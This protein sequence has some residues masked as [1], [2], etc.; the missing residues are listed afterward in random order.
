MNDLSCWE[1]KF[2]SCCYS[3][4]LLTKLLLLNET[5]T[6]KINILEIKK[7]I[8]YAK[9][10]HVDQKRQ[11]GEP[12]YSHPLQVAYMVADYS[13]TT[14]ILVT[15]IL[16]DTIED[17]S[18]TKRMIDL[19][20]GSVVANKVEDLT[21]VKFDRKISAAET[22]DLLWFQKKQDLLLIKYFDRLHNIQTISAMS[23]EKI[24][25]IVNETLKKFLTLSVYLGSKIPNMLIMEEQLT[26]LCYQNIANQPLQSNLEL[27]LDDN[28]HLSSLIVQND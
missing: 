12:Y 22:V 23:P 8:Y 16:H 14:D 2:E 10:Y 25:K 13:L 26:E 7:A 20:F 1:T 15:S 4:R 6:P 5:A 17:T 9:K 18:L 24:F 21:R 3:E 19:I 11:S 27:F 28:F